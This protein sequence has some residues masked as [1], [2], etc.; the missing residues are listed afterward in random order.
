MMEWLWDRT[1]NGALSL[2]SLRKDLENNLK[3]KL[4]SSKNNLGSYFLLRLR[5]CSKFEIDLLKSSLIKKSKKGI[6]FS[7]N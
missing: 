4:I 7:E 1:L 2:S 5:K 3:R 6:K